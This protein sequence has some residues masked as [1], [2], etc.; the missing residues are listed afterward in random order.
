MHYTHTAY[1]HAMSMLS[2]QNLPS[3]E[4]LIH[5]VTFLCKTCFIYFFVCTILAG[6]DSTWIYKIDL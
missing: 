4:K 5:I 6:Y 1:L 2:M 3:F